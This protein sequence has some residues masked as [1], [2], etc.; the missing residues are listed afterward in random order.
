MN[1]HS[2]A[3]DLVREDLDHVLHPVTL[4]RDHATRGPFVLVEGH[5]IWL[6]DPAGKEYIDGLA[7]LWN[8]AV[9][10]GRSAIAE[11]IRQQAGKLAY[12]P[13]F[14]GM[15]NDRA[16]ELG[17][18]LAALTPPSI[19]RFFWTSGGSEANDTGFKI[20][21]YFWRLQGCEEK[22]KVVS[23]LL[24]YH[25]ATYGALSATGLAHYWQNF[26]PMV[27]GFIHVPAPYC[28]RCP[29]G[30]QYGSCNLQCAG[31][32]EEAFTAAR[33]AVAEF[34]AEPVMGAGG[35]IIPPPEYFPRVR[36]ICD[37][38]G[39]LLHLDEVITGFGRTG[40]W[41]ACQHWNVQPDLLS[42]AKA[43]TSG[44]QPLGAVGLS[45]EIYQGLLGSEAAF[46]HG[47]TYNGHPVCC[48]AALAN[49]DIIEAERLVE[50]AATVGAYLLE[51]L[52]ELQELPHVGEVR[53]LGLL[54]A[55]EI[56]A[57]KATRAKFAPELKV[58][59]RIQARAR[60]GGLLCRAVS[61]VIC[62]APPLIIT[63]EEVD[64]VVSR[65]ATAIT[66]VGEG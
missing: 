9:G 21:R 7:G 11:A 32:V 28:Y 41:F 20:A 49:L 33:G 44:Y 66:G 15:A 65:L 58:G 37:Q 36:E 42:L 53:G 3:S 50:N 38:H 14:W 62:L 57:D 39:V 12:V 18:R 63:R 23:R 45:E 29:W 48:A 56:V 22:Y 34:I 43:M 1:Y 2:D 26:G 10:H 64:L 4:L 54:A 6:K 59:E 47:Y 30:Q 24:A 35:V 13:L 51:R 40:R 5:G 8:V 16:I 27:P 55:V 25:G 31:A 46:F 17:H 60:A 19:K 52:Q 61:D